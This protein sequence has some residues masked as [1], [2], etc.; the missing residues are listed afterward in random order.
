MLAVQLIHISLP[1]LVSWTPVQVSNL[2]TNHYSTEEA[3]P[4]NP[5]EEGDQDGPD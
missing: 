5:P 1:F 2:K 3:W 4:H